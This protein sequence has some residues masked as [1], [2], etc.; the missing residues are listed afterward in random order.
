VPGVNKRSRVIFLGGSVTVNNAL[1][2]GGLTITPLA[3]NSAK[4]AGACAWVYK[5]ETID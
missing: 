1:A 3:I 2:N 4:N 5:V